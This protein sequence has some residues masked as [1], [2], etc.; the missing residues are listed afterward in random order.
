MII[1][2]L[3]IFDASCNWRNQQPTKLFDSKKWSYFLSAP[4]CTWFLLRPYEKDSFLQY[5]VLQRF[6]GFAFEM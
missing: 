6:P 3:Y 1:F 2:P 5:K 4:H